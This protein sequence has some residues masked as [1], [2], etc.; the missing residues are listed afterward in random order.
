MARVRLVTVFVT[1]LGGGYLYRVTADMR[2]HFTDSRAPVLLPCANLSGIRVR[3]LW[4]H[5]DNDPT[6]NSARDLADPF[7]IDRASIL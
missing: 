6:H 5:Y 1:N 7:K 4:S 3:E 2:R